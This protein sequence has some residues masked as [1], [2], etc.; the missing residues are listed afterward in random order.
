MCVRS[1]R[2]A[3]EEG[4]R[5]NDVFVMA[6]VSELEEESLPR[7]WHAR[8]TSSNSGDAKAG[9]RR[10]HGPPRRARQDSVPDLRIESKPRIRNTLVS[11]SELATE[12]YRFR[13]I[14]Q[15]VRGRLLHLRRAPGRLESATR[16]GPA[17][18]TA[19]ILNLEHPQND[20]VLLMELG[21]TGR[22]PR[23]LY[24]VGNTLGLL[25]SPSVF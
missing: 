7:S 13:N 23:F 5:R 20:V 14:A 6:G 4:R 2:I 9:N 18:L 17:E 8:K 21:F 1:K 15:K 16:P 22:K 19:E 24:V 3:R 10:R 12:H 25:H 11:T